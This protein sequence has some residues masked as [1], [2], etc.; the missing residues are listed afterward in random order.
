MFSQ[1]RA[2]VA[3]ASIGVALF[4]GCGAAGPQ[5]RGGGPTQGHL[6]EQVLR[7]PVERLQAMQ[8]MRI[9]ILRKTVH[10]EE[11]RFAGMVRP[12]LA[13]QLGRAGFTPLESEQVLAWVD[14]ARADRARLSRWW[15][16]VTSG[17]PSQ[18]SMR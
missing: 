11:E 7:D 16:S 1:T 5:V 4:S 12:G 13:S 9:Q 6:S 2:L 15:S 14:E 8:W 10:I 3:A 17:A 18:H